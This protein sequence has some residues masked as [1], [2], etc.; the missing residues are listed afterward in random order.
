LPAHCCQP[1]VAGGV[2]YADL[3]SELHTHLAPAGFVYLEF[4]WVRPPLLQA[5]PF[6]STLGEVTLHKISQACVFIYSSHGKWVSPPPVEFSSHGHFYKLSHSWF[7]GVCCCSCPLQL[8][9][10]DG[11]PLPPLWC[12]GL[13]TLF[14]TCL[15]CCYCLLSRF[16]SLFSLGGGRSFQGPMLIWPRVVCGSTECHLAHLV[17]R[18]FPSHLGTGV[19]WHRSPPGF[20]V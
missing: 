12:S 4:S 20:S 1:A 17:V 3:R 13:P 10:C 2:I 18:I 16:F 19:W 6:P 15:F 7:L 11:F 9:C 8:A 14:A 5:F